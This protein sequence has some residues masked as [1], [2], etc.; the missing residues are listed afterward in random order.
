ML[1]QTIASYRE[2]NTNS[3]ICVQR[4]ILVERNEMIIVRR[5]RM[6]PTKRAI[7]QG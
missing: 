4:A 7:R 3:K 2:N 1:V 5:L 6:T